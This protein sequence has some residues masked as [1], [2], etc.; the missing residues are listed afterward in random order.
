M[1]FN[2]PNGTRGGQLPGQDVMGPINANAV[3]SI[4]DGKGFRGANVLVLVTIGAKSGEQR[5]TPV[6]YFRDPDGSFLIFASAA[7]AAKHPAWYFNL[8]AHPD[9]ARIVLDGVETPVTAE[10]LDGEERERLW[11]Q[12]TATAAGFAQ[13]Q[14]LTD[15]RIPLIRL[16]PRTAD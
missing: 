16:V 5:E 11:E 2:T 4:R 7:G 15:R 8:G 3:A 14:T 12:I 1:S 9:A 13:Y 6:A 10:E